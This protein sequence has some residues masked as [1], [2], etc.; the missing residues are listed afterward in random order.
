MMRDGKFVL[1]GL[2][3]AVA[4]C[5]TAAAFYFNIDS[6]DTAE[7][8]ALPETSEQNRKG[9]DDDFLTKGGDPLAQVTDKFYAHHK[10]TNFN[11]RE[12]FIEAV[13]LKEHGA[14]QAEVQSIEDFPL[15]MIATA[16]NIFEQRLAVY[17]KEDKKWSHWSASH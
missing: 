5:A 7:R 14:T 2:L 17:M 16:E 6:I 15:E 8:V 13:K 12:E 3:S 1:G 11:Q 9:R 10:P 4:A